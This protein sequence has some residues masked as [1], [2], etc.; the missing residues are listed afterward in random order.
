MGFAIAE[1]LAL[2]GAKVELVAGP[3]NLNISNPAIHRTN[4]DTAYEMY[5][6]CLSIFPNCDGAV[7]SAAVADYRTKDVSSL[8]IK[9]TDNEG[10]N[11]SLE[12]V[13]NKDILAALGNIKTKN[14]LLVGFSLETHNEFE[15]AGEKLKKKNL[16]LIVMNSLKNQGAGF[17][18][19]TNMISI[20]TS[21][22]ERID[23]PKKMKNEVAKD[24]VDF[25]IT[26]YF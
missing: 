12:L 9:K 18:V 11:L 3:V 17:S 19:D 25:I 26:R 8:K 22:G 23:Y 6:A 24:I 16:D 15:Y 21:G 14:Q 13:K 7:L 4:V 1:Q 20:L 10:E 5:K 2:A